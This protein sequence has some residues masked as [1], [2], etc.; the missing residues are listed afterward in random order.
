VIVNRVTGADQEVA[1]V[2][3]TDN[4]AT[5]QRQCRECYVDPSLVRYAVRLVA[6]TRNP[7][8]HQMAELAKYLTWGASPR[9]SIHLI[10]GAR[11]L[12]ILRGRNHVR[13]EDVVDLVPDVLRHRLSLSYEA[14][15]DAMTADQLI[16]RI[17]KQFPPPEKVL[18]S[19]VRVDATA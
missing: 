9:A 12:A 18:E 19:H 15:A 8:R 4:L 11:A 14:L 2:T 16:L 5:L 13:P 10:E 6:V 3:T 7:A 1:V 17:L